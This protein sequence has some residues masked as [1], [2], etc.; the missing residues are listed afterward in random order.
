MTYRVAIVGAGGIARRHARACRE[1][2]DA[3]LVALC[4]ARAEAV[5]RLGAE[6]GIA[7]RCVGLEALLG[8]DAIDIAVIATWGDSHAEVATALARSG[9]VRAILC[10][11][12]ISLSA[13]QTEAMQRE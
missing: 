10:E 6:V 4:D 5:E 8:G 12:P 9:K 13:A 7:R 3:E 1:V 2:A 11:K